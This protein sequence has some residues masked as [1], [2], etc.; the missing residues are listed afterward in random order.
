MIQVGQ[1]NICIGSL[2]DGHGG[3]HAAG[4]HGAQDGQDFPVAAGRCFVDAR[5]SWTTR[6][7]PRHRSCD[8]AFIQENQLVER[9]RADFFAELRALLL[10]GFGVSLG[11]MKRLFF[12]RTP[13]RFSTRHKC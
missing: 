6:I 9:G 12:R 8:T 11:G 5:A 13:N 7:E 10:I 3:D 4:T 2:F 1:E